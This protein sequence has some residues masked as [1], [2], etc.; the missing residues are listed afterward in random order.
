MRD[1]T[2]KTSRIALLKILRNLLTGNSLE[3]L[4]LIIDLI[5]YLPQIRLHPGMYEVL[6]HE[7]R[8]ELQ[9]RRGHEAVCYKR[10]RV[11]FLQDNIIAY[12]DQAWGDGDIFAEYKCSPGEA[13]DRYREG[14]LYRV[15]IS[16]RQTK[17]RGD[18]EEFHIE[19]TIHD[20][21]TQTVEDFQTEISHHTHRAAIRVVFPKSRPP[22]YLSGIEQNRKRTTP[23]SPDQLQTL[24]DG[25]IQANWTI[26]R[27]RLHEGYILR[28]T[29]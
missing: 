6:E 24:P 5:A 28:W 17:H 14:H 20:G 15:L 19:R 23:L 27:P 11:R 2:T 13:V 26:Q 25:R 3:F 10:Q 16:L 1:I 29:W 22:K 21:F 4:N 12:Q 7:L 18:V 8:L 9:D